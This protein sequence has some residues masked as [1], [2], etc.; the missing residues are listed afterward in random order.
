MIYKTD[1]TLINLNDFK[2]NFYYE[3]KIINKIKCDLIRKE[4]VCD[5]SID[6]IFVNV[7]S[8]SEGFDIYYLDK[9]IALIV[10]DSIIVDYEVN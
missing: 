10:Y 4:E 1:L 9:K 2:D 8:N 5:F 7:Y 6:G 3:S